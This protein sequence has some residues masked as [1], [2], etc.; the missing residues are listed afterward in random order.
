MENNLN[1]ITNT[2]FGQLIDKC[3]ELNID[4]A[5]ISEFQFRHKLDAIFKSILR[6][7]KDI[8]LNREQQEEVLSDIISFLLGLGP[9]ENVLRDQ[10]VTEIMVNG[11]KQVYIEKQGHLELTNITFRD[12]QHL[13]YFIEKIL[14]PLG[15]RVTTYEPFVDAR[16]KDGSRVNV[17][18]SPVSSIGPI[19]TIRKFSH[20]VLTVD[21][22]IKLGSITNEVAEFLKAC[23]M[24]RLNILVC[25]STSA[26]KSSLL[27]ILGSFIPKNERI[28]TIEDTLELRISNDHVVPLETREHN[29]EGKGEITI[30]D[31][32]RNALHM[33]P[34][35]IIVGEVRGDEVL[36]MIQ[37]MNVG[38]EGSMTT[39]HANSV[40][41]ALD[42]L[43][44][45][46]LMG[47][48]N[49]SSEVA[50]RQIIS[51]VQLVIDMTR[52][53]DGARKITRISEVLKTKDYQLQDIFVLEEGRLK[54]T[55]TV[56][57]FYHRLKEQAGYENKDFEQ[58][59]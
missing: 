42:R 50:K 26:G 16:L 45:L 30:R 34:D 2:I 44:V 3:R 58:N 38:H 23:V 12:E 36:D 54:Y 41:E 47:S 53:P 56:P 40:L 29:I 52:F 28:I 10:D 32:L 57:S 46:A 27:N 19:L 59:K 14:S 8:S 11:P 6:E 7:N 43:E 5:Q 1:E 21:D 9:I 20:R 18:K 39:L 22:F 4:Y 33:R 37:A 48:A 49:I 13:F 17:V 25:G 31:L 15:R 35:R 51:A 24:A 55:G